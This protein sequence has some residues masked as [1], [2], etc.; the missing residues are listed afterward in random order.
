[1][2]CITIGEGAVRRSAM[3]QSQATDRTR[4]APTSEKSRTIVEVARDLGPEASNPDVAD[5]VEDR[6]GD[7]PD[8]SWVSRVRSKYV[9]AEGTVDSKGGDA[10]RATPERSDAPY[11]DEDLWL[12]VDALAGRLDRFTSNVGAI[13]QAVSELEARVEE[14]EA[15]VEEVD[16]DADTDREDLADHFEELSDRLRGDD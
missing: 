1:M 13:D 15:A 10:P 2:R 7:R 12:R 11:D 16:V 3:A 4:D 8:P 5:E 14:L 6:I 9:D